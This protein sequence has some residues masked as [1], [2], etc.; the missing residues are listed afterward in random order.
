MKAMT[1]MAAMVLA[2]AAVGAPVADHVTT[3]VRRGISPAAKD[4][5]HVLVANVGGAVDEAVFSEAAT[6]AISKLAINIWTNSLASFDA[7]ALPHDPKLVQKAFGEKAKVGVFLTKAGNAPQFM[8]VP[9]AWCRVNVEGLDAGSPDAQTFKDRVAKMVLKGLAY[10]AGSGSSLD[11]RC[12]MFFGGA[13]L[14][15]LDNI[16]IRLS[17][18]V[19]FPMLETLKRVGG[20]EI[21]TRPEE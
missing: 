20:H 7:D 5:N 8:A 4:I 19:Y 13:T 3:N 12:S 14:E 17:P 11:A 16:G 2:A 10:A 6:Y 9:G 18:G 21:V 1:M 15:G